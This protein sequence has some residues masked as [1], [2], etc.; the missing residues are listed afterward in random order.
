MHSALK[1]PIALTSSR[2]P[3]AAL[4]RQCLTSL[5]SPTPQSVGCGST[6]IAAR[7]PW[8][9]RGALP[10]LDT[11]IS[12]LPRACAR[13]RMHAYWSVISTLTCTCAR[14]HAGDACGISTLMRTRACR[15][16]VSKVLPPS[17][18]HPRYLS[19]WPLLLVLC[20]AM[21]VCWSL[22]CLAQQ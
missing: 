1:Q 9:T 12:T 16:C 15:R 2:S 5:T 13:M 18:A 11:V 14:T 7:G 4:L 19:P 21:W 8:T 10:F 22:C 3:H 20:R 6:L 17:C